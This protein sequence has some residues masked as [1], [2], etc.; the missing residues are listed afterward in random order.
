V[1]V[2]T[3]KE[4]FMDFNEYFK[5]GM[6]FYEDRDYCPALVNWE[7]ALKLDPSNEQLRGII[8]DTKKAAQAKAE[9]DRSR[10]IADDL[11]RQL[12]ER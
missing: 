3:V 7:A 6:E 11:K 2:N 4:F 1:G 5:R 9:A 8:E 12:R 10:A